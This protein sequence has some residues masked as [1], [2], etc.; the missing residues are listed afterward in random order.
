MV[1]SSICFSGAGSLFCS[2]PGFPMT[3]CT[4]KPASIAT[5][6]CSTLSTQDAC[7]YL[8]CG[9]GLTN[10]GLGPPKIAS[11]YQT[12]LPTILNL[13][14]NFMLQNCHKTIVTCLPYSRLFPWVQTFVKCWRPASAIIFNILV[15]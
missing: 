12:P 9:R 3:P 13:P 5:S 1:V 7:D 8:Y 10:S 4:W 15:T 14:L 2:T 6:A 11:P